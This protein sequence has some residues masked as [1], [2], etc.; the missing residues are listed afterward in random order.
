MAYE[1]FKTSYPGVR[2]RKHPTRKH[3]AKR[4]QYFTIRYQANG[5]RQEEALGWATG[6]WTAEKA[7]ARLA[8]LK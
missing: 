7:N 6:G 8:E 2:F 4:D 3:G 1:W 5:K